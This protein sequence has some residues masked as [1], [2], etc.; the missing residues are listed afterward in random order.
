M[1]TRLRIRDHMKHY[2]PI[3]SVVSTSVVASSTLEA[4]CQAVVPA[5]WTYAVAVGSHFD[6]CM[7]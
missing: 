7:R 3:K 6:R 2:Y 1:F 5:L 4:R